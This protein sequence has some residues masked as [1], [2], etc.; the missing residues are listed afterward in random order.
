MATIKRTQRAI[1]GTTLLRRSKYF[2]VAGLVATSTI[3]LV[4]IPGL[5]QFARVTREV[6]LVLEAPNRLSAR[7][8]EQINRIDETIAT[9]TSDVEQLDLDIESLADIRA[10][11]LVRVQR[12]VDTLENLRDELMG[13]KGKGYKR[14]L[15]HQGKIIQRLDYYEE[16]FQKTY[17]DF[18]VDVSS[19]NLKRVTARQ[20]CTTV[21]SIIELRV[22]RVQVDRRDLCLFLIY[23]STWFLSL[24]IY[25]L[26]QDATD[27]SVDR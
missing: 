3:K 23:M 2:T 26:I 18:A 7:T 15:F 11:Y 22:G 14:Q 20:P 1:F 27:G 19:M 16:F 12:F 24:Q 8:Q 6:A 21:I 13:I 9:I 10:H 17:C 4:D 25:D 5:Q